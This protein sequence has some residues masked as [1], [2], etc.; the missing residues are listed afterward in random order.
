M[1]GMARRGDRLGGSV[2]SARF[3]QEAPRRF[4]TARLC[5]RRAAETGV[6]FFGH[7]RG[8]FPV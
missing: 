3:I 2:F 1:A 4:A 7:T 5:N 8:V 6:F